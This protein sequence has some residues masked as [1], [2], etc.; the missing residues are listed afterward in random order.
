MD[1][2]PPQPSQSRPAAPDNW[3]ELLEDWED[4]RQG[5]Y[6][7]DKDEAV[8]D[9][10]RHLDADT[11]GEQALFWTLGL[12]LL[13]PY[14][15]WGHPGPGVEAAVV[16]AL[17]KVERALGAYTCERDR[18]P[19]EDGLEAQLKLLPRVLTALSNPGEAELDD[20]AVAKAGR[21]KPAAPEGQRAEL[22]SH[23]ACP[24]NVAGFARAIMA[25]VDPAH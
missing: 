4:L 13:S 2:I 12:A 20:L 24:R 11:T 6:L 23:W 17:A 16:E 8:L 25:H 7:G 21:S 10:V 19:H 9:C 14:V 22:L 1:E 3:E 18:H 15:V 5:Y